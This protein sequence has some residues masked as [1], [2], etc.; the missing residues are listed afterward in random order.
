MSE[1]SNAPHNLWRVIQIV[2]KNDLKFEIV[3]IELEN[4]HTQK[5]KTQNETHL[6]YH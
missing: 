5:K 2:W 4:Q 3:K 6:I 1:K